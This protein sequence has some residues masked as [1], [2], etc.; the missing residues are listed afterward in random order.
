MLNAPPWLSLPQRHLL[1]TQRPPLLLCK[2]R[3]LLPFGS[4]RGAQ[5]DPPDAFSLSSRKEA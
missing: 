5:L 1:V 3:A 2:R 4:S